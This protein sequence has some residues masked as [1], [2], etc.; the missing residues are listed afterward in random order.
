MGK[1]TV[2]YHRHPFLIHHALEL[3]L[4]HW[5]QGVE[6]KMWLRVWERMRRGFMH[7][8]VQGE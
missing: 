4:K 2:L 5:E 3:K 8:R 1:Y 7:L 6:V